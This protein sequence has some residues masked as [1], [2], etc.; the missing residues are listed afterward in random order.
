MRTSDDE[1]LYQ[2]SCSLYDPF[3]DSDEQNETRHRR[4]AAGICSDQGLC[5]E[6]PRHLQAEPDGGIIV[7]RV[8]GWCMQGLHH[9][10]STVTRPGPV[11]WSIWLKWLSTPRDQPL[12]QAGV[13]TGRL[14]K[15]LSV[16]LRSADSVRFFA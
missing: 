12:E 2:S 14:D 6:E 5:Y 15:S 16:A 7:D 1:V 8:W 9:E 3:G 4:G 10:M 13:L 11:A